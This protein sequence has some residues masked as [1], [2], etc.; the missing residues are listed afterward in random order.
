MIDAATTKKAVEAFERN[1]E[2]GTC[3]VLVTSVTGDYYTG[4]EYADKCGP[5]TNREL[6]GMKRMDG[7]VT[8]FRSLY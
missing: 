7:T 2:P 8:Y 3:F 4:Q 1:A 5:G 6:V